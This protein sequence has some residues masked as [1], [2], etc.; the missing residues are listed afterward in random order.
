M[1]EILSAMFKESEGFADKIKEWLKN[2]E[3]VP[4]DEQLNYLENEALINKRKN[5][6]KCKSW[7]RWRR[8]CAWAANRV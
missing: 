8:W 5:W 1:S 2:N 4:L 3:R 6:P 7:K